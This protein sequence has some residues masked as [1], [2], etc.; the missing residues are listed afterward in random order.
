MPLLFCAHGIADGITGP[1]LNCKFEQFYTSSHL[2][3]KFSIQVE[4]EAR[5]GQNRQLLQQE[6][7]QSQAAVSEPAASSTVTP[8]W[9]AG[10][11]NVF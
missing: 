8:P 2:F 10:K 11:L 9:K 1:G 4:V 6:I 5:R 3:F 7:Q